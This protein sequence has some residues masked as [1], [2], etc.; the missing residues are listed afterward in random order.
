MWIQKHSVCKFNAQWVLS[1]YFK[2]S[3]LNIWF[4]IYLWW[5]PVAFIQAWL[6]QPRKSKF[7]AKNVILFNQTPRSKYIKNLGLLRDYHIKQVSIKHAIHK[8]LSTWSN[9]LLE[10]LYFYDHR[11][12]CHIFFFFFQAYVNLVEAMEWKQF[13]ILYEESEGLVRLQEVLK[14]STRSKDIKILVRQLIPGPGDD[15]RCVF[16]IYF[17]WRI[18]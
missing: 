18:L 1:V 12:V 6:T 5:P 8:I 10:S 9:W 14:M 7:G 11:T 16:A 3:A 17:L 2:M 4:L 13:V 15:Y